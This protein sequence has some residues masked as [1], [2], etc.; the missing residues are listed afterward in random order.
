MRLTCPDCGAQYKVPE[1]AIPEAGRDVQCSACGATWVQPH[2]A[3]ALAAEENAPAEPGAASGPPPTP[4]PAQR[5]LDP[6]VAD[7]LRTEAARER[8]KR[9]AESTGG[10]GMQIDPPSAAPGD[11]SPVPPLQG[12]RRA[13]GDTAAPASR[14]GTL[15]DPEDITSSLT[16]ARGGA[17]RDMAAAPPA[18][19][20]PARRSGFG[21]GFWVAVIAFGLAACVY[22][23]APDLIALVPEAEAPVERYVAAIDGARLRLDA[24]VDRM[25]TQ[26]T[27][28]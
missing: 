24:F 26:I 16:P 27:G 10:V 3:A 9:A 13:T 19:R 14:Q 20:V 8:A 1:A 12:A 18:A 25:M 15:P 6:E 22:L 23:W 11:P 7:I 21:A 2:P 5:R 28:G 17:A 4:E